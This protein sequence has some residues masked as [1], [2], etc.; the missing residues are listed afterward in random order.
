M[1]SEE[2][3][4]DHE[5]SSHRFR[6]YIDK[7]QDQ[8]E[9][10]C[11]FCNKTADDIRAEYYEYMKDPDSDFEEVSM[12][13]LVIMTDKLQKPV[14]AGCYFAI[15]KSPELVEEILQRPEEE[16]WGTG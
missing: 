13:D 6:E 5:H 16:V 3:N 9:N 8:K 14:C 12:D 15:K 1:S 2:N 11:W 10:H 4:M 7:I